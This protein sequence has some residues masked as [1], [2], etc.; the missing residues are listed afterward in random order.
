MSY[1][2]IGLATARGSG[3]NGYV[4][5][6]ISHIKPRTYE[7]QRGFDR[8]DPRAAPKTHPVSQD[9]VNHNKKRQIEVKLFEL[10]DRLEDEGYVVAE[11]EIES[12]VARLR[13]Q[14]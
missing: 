10:R 13:S 7:R 11:D 8:D 2:N 6:N 9:I 5:R 14:L 1:N 4:Q 12:Q 3:T